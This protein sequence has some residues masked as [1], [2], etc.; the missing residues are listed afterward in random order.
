MKT[1]RLIGVFY[2]AVVMIVVSGTVVRAE[3]HHVAD[4]SVC[5]YSG[6]A[7][8]TACVSCP[9][10]VMIKCEIMTPNSG[11]KG[12][13]FGP[14]VWTEDPY[15]GVCEVCHTLTD[16]HRN[17]SS[18]DNTHFAAENCILCHKHSDQFTHGG[19]QPCDTCHG[20]E[21]GAGTA[22]SHATHTAETVAR[23][24]ATAMACGDCHDA[25]NFPFFGDNGDKE[26]LSATT[27]CDNCHS[28]GGA[29]DGLAAA[30]ANWAD[31]VYEEDG[32]L[33]SGNDKWCAGC[34]DE[35]PANS[36][37]DGSG[38]DAPNTIGD[39]STYGFYKSGHGIGCLSC[40]DSGKNHI[41]HEHRTYQAGVT[42]YSD[43]YRLKDID[44]QP[45]MILP[46]TWGGSLNRLEDFALC[47][48]CHNPLD[49]LDDPVVSN[50]YQD[51]ATPLNGHNYHLNFNS[52][53]ADTDYDGTADSS[54]TCT[55]CHNV[56]GSPSRAMVRNGQ[57]I[58][59]P[60]T[61]NK[62]PALNFSYLVKPP[63]PT[64][65]ATWS[66]T[67]AEDGNYNVYARW[68]AHSNWATDA[69]YTVTYDG[70]SQTVDVNQ[71][72]NGGVWN[73][74]GTF[75]LVTTATGEVM[76]GNDA[77][78]R[79][80][81]DSIRIE[82]AGPGGTDIIIDEEAASFTGGS[83][84]T[85][86]GVPESLNGDH[87]WHAKN[88]EPD[89]SATIDESEGGIMDTTFTTIADN[90]VCEGACHGPISYL[91]PPYLGPKLI[92]PQATPDMVYND[93]SSSTLITAS[94]FDPDG[95]V[96]S[97]IVDLSPIGGSASQQLYDTGTLG[98]VQSGDGIYSFSALVPSYTIDGGKSLTV[99]ATD[100]AP[101]TG[102]HTL[103]LFVAEPGAIYIDNTDAQFTCAWTYKANKAVAF[104]GDH[105]WHNEN[106]ACSATWIPDIP[107][108]GNYNV[109]VWWEHM[110]TWA[111]DAPFTVNYTG[112]GG[113]SQTF[114]MN[115]EINGGQ[116]NQLGSAYFPFAIGTSGSI[117]LTNDA[118]DA[119][120]ADAVKFE[121]VP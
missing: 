56:H 60:G 21:G 4:C 68:R 100:S 35:V 20:L 84:T 19:G 58:S 51:R 23:G 112:G 27:V 73:L 113:G 40:H 83:W 115:Q 59:T 43:S 64:A 106:E 47:F 29:F 54:E 25:N 3:F 5:H 87:R 13:V 117:V 102:Q 66:F 18:G 39:N 62:V 41:D 80:V 38:S 104:N 7:E 95:D 92:K 15:N 67:V 57:L 97:I 98:D 46:R 26:T 45:A 32:T 17:D 118:N 1:L 14:Y 72:I 31:G 52:I 11:L 90:G 105:H 103:L 37:A 6:G 75:S 76:L 88:V 50:F 34:H 70:G 94:V 77:D 119:V 24:P 78:D 22:F 28:E 48:D 108:A 9:N 109:Y 91:R 93:S 55:T 96:T 61:T 42:P 107:Q 65:T 53:H 121:P 81:A 86:T 63:Y 116:W 120:V 16:Y 114:D 71:E 101:N 111:T 110:P 8:S 74:L 79:V 69:P 82:G 89:P 49:V 10:N 99:T 36:E 44:G 2:A 85:A 12:A 30:K 33:K